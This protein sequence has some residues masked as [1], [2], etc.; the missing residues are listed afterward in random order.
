M[1]RKVRIKPSEKLN[2]ESDREW[3]IHNVEFILKSSSESPF[4][5]NCITI[6]V[7]PH[8]NSLLFQYNHILSA[9]CDETIKSR[10]LINH[11]STKSV[12]NLISGNPSSLHNRS[13]LIILRYITSRNNRSRVCNPTSV[14]HS[15]Q[16]ME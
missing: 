15:Q 9:K 12:E 3:E 13:L 11:N 2:I 8:C 7:L 1:R 5:I 6:C 16:I 4:R 10:D 14:C